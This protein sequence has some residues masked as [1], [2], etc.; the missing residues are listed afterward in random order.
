VAG[1]RRSYILHSKQATSSP[2]GLWS[3]T[4]SCCGERAASP[5]IP[6]GAAHWG[7]PGYFTDYPVLDGTAAEFLI[8]CEAGLVGSISRPWTARP[9]RRTSVLLGGGVPIIE[10][11]TG[12]DALTAPEGE[13]LALPLR[14]PTNN[15][16]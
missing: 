15:A 8:T 12:T 3:R 6:A 4:A 13:F 7:L 1:R 14:A 10:N 16:H 11:L 2:P 5:S 9:S